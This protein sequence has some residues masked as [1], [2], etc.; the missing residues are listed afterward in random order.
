[1][2]ELD[3]SEHDTLIIPGGFGAAKNLCSFGFKGADMTVHEDIEKILKDFKAQ[4]KVIGLTCISPII[5]AKVFGSQGVKLTLGGRGENFPFAGSIDA[6]ESFG[7]THEEANVGDV[8]TDWD[9]SLVTTPA[10]MQGDAA[11]DAVFDGIQ[12]FLR[13]VKSLIRQKEATQT[14][15]KQQSSAQT[16]S[17]PTED[18]MMMRLV[19]E[20]VNR[21]WSDYDTSKDGYLTFEES[22]DFIRDSFGNASSSVFSEAD[23]KAL[24]NR[25]D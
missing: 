4:D 1:M 15:A 9:N 18:D 22:Q 2:D 16:T 23:I 8:V 19:L 5:A 3:A 20:S 21:I 7:A 24:F 10:Y 13:K 11:P 25:I 17:K 12:L 6:A 14:R